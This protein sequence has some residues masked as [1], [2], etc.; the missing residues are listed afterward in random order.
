[1]LNGYVRFPGQSQIFFFLGGERG[2]CPVY[3]ISFA[4]TQIAPVFH[5]HA[6]EAEVSRYGRHPNEYFTEIAVENLITYRHK[7]AS[8]T[9]LHRELFQVYQ[10]A[11]A[12]KPVK[13]LSTHLNGKLFTATAI[14]AFR[15]Y[16]F[17]GASIT[18][19]P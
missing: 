18:R 8:L 5:P 11:H 14:G 15:T 13:I 4:R 19:Q 2:V 9:C 17:P 6:D 7:L 3:R 16:V 1:M 10:L 12:Y